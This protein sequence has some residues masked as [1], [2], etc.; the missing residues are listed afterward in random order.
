MTRPLWR[1]YSSGMIGAWIVRI[2]I[3]ALVGGWLYMAVTDFDPLPNH[4]KPATATA[5]CQIASQIKTRVIRPN[6]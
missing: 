6:P 3:A 2:A 4:C 1:C 5:D